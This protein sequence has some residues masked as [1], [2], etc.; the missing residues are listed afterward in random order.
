M[1]LIARLKTWGATEDVTA[2]DLNAEFNNILDNLTPSYVDDYSANVLQMQTTADPG[3]V[4]TES[5]ATTLAGELQRLRHMLKEITGE[6]KWYE[7]P[8]SSLAG[9]AN[10][11]GTGLTDNRLVSGRVLSTSN[12]PAFLVPNGAAR[13]VKVDGNPTN[14]LYYVN[15]IE[16]TIDADVTI[17]NLTAA[18]ASN[19]TCLINDANAADQWWTKI[20]GEDGSDII[21]DTM[22]SEISALIGKFAAFKLNNGSADEYFL[23]YVKSSTALSKVR[24]GYFFDSTDAPVPRISFANNDTITL[25]KLTWVFAKSD[26]TLT[27]T[28]NNPVWSDDEPTSPA[29][30][31]YWF[32]I[33]AN[34]WKVYGV[35]SYSDANAI[36]VGVCAQNTTACVAA[37]SFE[38]FANYASLNTMEIIAESNT[39]VK[40]KLPG[41]QLSVFGEV[42][43][44]DHNIRTWDMTLDLDSGVTEAAST[45]YYFY[46]TDTGDVKISDVKPFDRREDLQGYYHPHQ[47]WRCVGS[48]FNNGSSNLESVESYYNSFESR[49]I[50]PSQTAALNVEVVP[51]IIPVD[52]SGGA[53]TIYLPDAA[54]T[55]GQEF[56]F[57]RTDSTFANAVTLDGFGSQTIGGQTT[58]GLYT[59]NESLRI[60]SDGSN[61]LV[62]SHHTAT[63]L[64]AFPN[65]A[66][67]TLLT[68]VTTSPTYA[69]TVLFNKA[70]WRREGPVAHI[71]WG[72]EH[73]SNAGA[74]AGTGMY[75]FNLPTGLTIDTTVH[76][77]STTINANKGR[78]GNGFLTAVG[79]A[80][81]D[82]DV[83][84]YDSTRLY[85]TDSTSNWSNVNFN[86][87]NANFR[88]HLNATVP[89]VGW[90]P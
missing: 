37:R 74:A 1:G 21:V 86:I 27:A 54:L 14:F 18:P 5:Q 46:V 69:T 49:I 48:A 30:G 17:E 47:S 22:G 43:K 44:A 29:I 57:H 19:N 28:Y 13:T 24:R 39:Q 2:A 76:N 38:F 7:S 79:S 52:G 70:W 56:I 6:D 8:T 26:E 10:A 25:L 65:H 81:R 83:F 73:D 23:A 64:I 32:D 3:E 78:V 34:K 50:M 41:A 36:L 68:A 53:Y 66:A 88:A 12:Q 80:Q 63:P 58:F 16:Y 89:I 84:T 45:F 31:D 87:A 33:S 59:Q 51:K 35:G 60:I 72:Y 82:H 15:G 40:S 77:S 90:Q 42:I 75:L 11:L 62:L 71:S 55:R 4:G 61:Y 9:L 67:G 20:A 85:M